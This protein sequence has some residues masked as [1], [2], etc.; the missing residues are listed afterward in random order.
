M[1]PRDLSSELFTLDDAAEDMEWESL[2]EGIM[3]TLEA[4]NQS[5]GTLQDV[6]IPTGQV[7]T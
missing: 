6:I 7:F 4:L 2:N 3:A 5:R 1:S